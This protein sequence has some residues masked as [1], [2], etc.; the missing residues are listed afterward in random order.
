MRCQISFIWTQ[1]HICLKYSNISQFVMSVCQRWCSVILFCSSQTGN[2][3]SYWAVD[4]VY[5]QWGL[6]CLC[7]SFLF[8]FFNSNWYCFSYSLTCYAESGFFLWS[9]RKICDPGLTSFEPEALG[10]LVEGHDFHRFYFENG[11]FKKLWS[12]LWSWQFSFLAASSGQ[13]QQIWNLLH[14]KRAY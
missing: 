4:W 11:E 13:R 2:Y 12:W 3:Q 7:V 14:N 10:N 8:L 5:Q 1:T 9:Y 6:W